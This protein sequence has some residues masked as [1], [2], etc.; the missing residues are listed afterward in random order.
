MSGRSF[1]PSPVPCAS[2]RFWAPF[3]PNVGVC[4]RGAPR[5]VESSD[6]VAHWPE[7]FA[8][9]ACGE[10]TLRAPE[11]ALQVCA[12]CAYWVPSTRDG[13]V[14]PV[15]FND[16]VRAWWHR[17]GRCV[18]H[19]PGPLAAPGARLVWPATHGSDSCGEGAPL[20]PPPPVGEQA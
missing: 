19:A 5:P 7:T 1:V 13:G 8:E 20:A 3:N 10:G 6:T 18:R 2:C 17:A 4:R 9:E 15:D 16:R 14:A 11:A 12:E